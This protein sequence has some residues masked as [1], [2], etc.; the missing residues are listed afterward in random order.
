[1]NMSLR[2]SD[3]VAIPLQV[4][5]VHEGGQLHASGPVADSVAAAGGV[6][7]H[8]TLYGGHR[9]AVEVFGLA[10][11]HVPDRGQPNLSQDGVA[12]FGRASVERPGW[13]GHV[14]FWRGRHFITDE[15]DRNYLS[16][17]L[18]G[19]RYRRTRDYAEAGLAR[20]FT[21]AANAILEASAR[22]HRIE[23]HHEYSFRVS[24]IVTPSWRVR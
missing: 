23:N 20:R 12:F 7:M 17:G 9:A 8:R 4:H 19:G 13:R 24:S 5:V 2:V 1:M 11:R 10:T 18:D 14:I 21:L 6:E 22:F 15:G 16:L 3:H